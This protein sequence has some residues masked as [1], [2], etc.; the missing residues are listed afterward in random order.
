[1]EARD[2]LVKARADAGLSLRELG[3]AVGHSAALVCEWEHGSR[4]PTFAGALALEK[5]LLEFG[6]PVVEDWGSDRET[7]RR[8]VA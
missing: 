7:A 3:H 2:K 1:M 6:G 4:R 5:A 8:V